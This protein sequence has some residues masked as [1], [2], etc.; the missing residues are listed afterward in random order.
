MSLLVCANWEPNHANH[1]S[2]LHANDLMQHWPSND[3]WWA[4]LQ[5]NSLDGLA[6]VVAAADEITEV[7][8]S[9]FSF[10]LDLASLLFLEL[11][12]LNVSL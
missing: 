7:L 4:R 8:A 10:H 11:Q 9:H 1:G 12:L 5:I 2:K 3:R 6:Q